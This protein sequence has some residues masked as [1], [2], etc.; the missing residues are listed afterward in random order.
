MGLL[1]ALVSTL[2]GV[3][4]ALLTGLGNVATAAF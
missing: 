2:G 1:S 4:G 3:V